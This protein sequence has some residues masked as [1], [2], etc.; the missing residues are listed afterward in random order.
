ME[1]PLFLG[2]SWWRRVLLAIAVGV[3]ACDTS[4][5][6]S[7]GVGVRAAWV[8]SPAQRVVQVNFWEAGDCFV[9]PNGTRVLLN[10]KA[11]R[12][13]MAGGSSHQI[14][15]TGHRTRKLERSIGP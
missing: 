1:E 11:L 14:F 4:T 6:G 8:G 3:L 7:I 12:L 10:G 13:T 2:F 9:I 5:F 15:A